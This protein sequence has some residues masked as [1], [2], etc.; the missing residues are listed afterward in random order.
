MVSA[1][2]DPRARTQPR[3]R[4]TVSA[5]PDPRARTQPRLR[6]T[7][8]A[9]PDPRA[10]TQPRLRKTVSASP[11]PRARTQPRLWKT[12]SASPDPRARTQPRRR[13]SHRLARPRARTDHVTGGPSSATLGLPR[14]SWTEA[15]ASTSS[16]LRPSGSYGSIYPR[17]GP[18]R[19]PFTGSSPGS[20]SS[21][22]GNS[23]CPS[24]SGLPPTSERKPS[25]SRWS[26]SEE[27]TT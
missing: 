7:V 21:P 17:S 25:R 14:S 1:S 27:P 11:D 26:G 5:S 23:I 2:P 19:R 8:S 12:V 13:R 10:R 4:K 3:L 18:A 24:A 20:T 15:A 22:L 6:K 9:S 16:T